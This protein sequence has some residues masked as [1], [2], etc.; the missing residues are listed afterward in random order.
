[1]YPARASLHQGVHWKAADLEVM[2]DYTKAT[3]V[4]QKALDLDSNCKEVADG[5]QLCMMVQYNLHNSPNDV[6]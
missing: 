1:M 5:Y 2:K 4:Y 6:K 3:D